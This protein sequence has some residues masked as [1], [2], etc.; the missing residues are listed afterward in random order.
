MFLFF[1]SSLLEIVNRWADGHGILAHY[2]TKEQV[3]ALIRAL[4]QN[5]ERRANALSKIR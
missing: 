2:L 3:K 1:K 5:N 4:F